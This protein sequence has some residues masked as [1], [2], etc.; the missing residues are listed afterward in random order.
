MKLRLPA[1]LWTIFMG[2]LVWAATPI[3]TDFTPANGPVGTVVTISGT[4]LT[5]ASAM[6]FNGVT[7]KITPISVSSLKATVPNGATSG[8]ITVTTPDGTAIS[9]ADFSVT[10]RINAVDGAA[11]VWVP[12]GTFTMGSPEGVGEDREHPA[13]LVTLTGFWLYK[14]EVTVA[15]YRD[16]CTA[17]ERVLPKF[18]DDC[19]SWQGKRGWKDPALQQHPIVNVNWNDAQAYAAWAKAALPTEAQWGICRA[20]AGRA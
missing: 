6:T 5:G 12:G 7:T 13:H 14:Y 1:C 10:S 15:Q 8:K 4:N 9:T 18:P 2:S 17:T 11:L 16:F 3:I 20:R 19:W